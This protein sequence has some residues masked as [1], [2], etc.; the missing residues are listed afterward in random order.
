MQTV[1]HQCHSLLDHFLELPSGCHRTAT[2]HSKAAH[3]PHEGDVAVAPHIDHV[4][5]WVLPALELEL[6]ILEHRQQLNGIHAKGLQVVN[7]QRSN[8]AGVDDCCSCCN[9]YLG[10][11]KPHTF[12]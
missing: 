4:V 10:F 1:R 7:L 11:A 5:T 12:F 3:G 9:W 8:S 2:T 6:V